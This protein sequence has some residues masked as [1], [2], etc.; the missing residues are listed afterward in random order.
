M[1]KFSLG[2]TIDCTIS[3]ITFGDVAFTVHPYEMFDSNGKALREGTVGNPDYAAED[4]LENP[5]TM[6]F[7]LSKGNGGVGYIPSAIAYTHGGYEPDCTKFA[8]GSG[9]L[10]VGD[11]LHLLSE[12]YAN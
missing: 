1:S 5:F 8:A 12:L 9:E 2:P 6:T 11:Y 10:L 4:Q 3:V 7:V